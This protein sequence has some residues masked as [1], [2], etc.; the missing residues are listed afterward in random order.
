MYKTKTVFRW[1]INGI[2]G[3]HEISDIGRVRKMLN[4]PFLVA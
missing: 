3:D 2:A 4:V 1:L